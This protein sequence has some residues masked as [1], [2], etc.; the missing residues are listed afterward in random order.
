MSLG[1]GA[2]GAGVNGGVRGAGGVTYEWAR[3]A[4]W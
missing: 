2:G 4:G 3:G 1:L